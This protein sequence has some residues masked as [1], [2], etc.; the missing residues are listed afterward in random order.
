MGYYAHE[1]DKKAGLQR[2]TKAIAIVLNNPNN[3]RTL[4]I[5]PPQ[6]NQE[7]RADPPAAAVYHAAAANEAASPYPC[8]TSVDIESIRVS[9]PNYYSV[10]VTRHDVLPSDY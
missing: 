2:K 6:L 1:G 5:C 7:A 9:L 4:G 3:L 8:S 10:T